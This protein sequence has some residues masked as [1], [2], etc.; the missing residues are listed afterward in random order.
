MDPRGS[1]PSRTHALARTVSCE[2]REPNGLRG[3]GR[4]KSGGA[5][6][7]VS[8]AKDSPVGRRSIGMDDNQTVEH[9]IAEGSAGDTFFV[10][11]RERCDGVS[12]N[13]FAFKKTPEQKTKGG[14]T[15]A[16]GI[17]LGE[18]VWSGCLRDGKWSG[19]I[20]RPGAKVLAMA[21]AWIKKNT[22]ETK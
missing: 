3:S 10:A 1:P 2:P 15:I 22:E 14:A 9:P 21:Q 6:G 8:R 20:G 4:E 13:A 16:A 17:A 11:Y 19:I 18:C 7:S 5:R 12:V